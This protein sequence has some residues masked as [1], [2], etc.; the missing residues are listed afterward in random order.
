M[1][2]ARYIG[3]F[4]L[5]NEQCYIQGLGTLQLIRKPATYDG[6]EL[7]APYHE[8]TLVP[9]GNVDEA[10]ANY[11]ATNEQISITKASNALKEYSAE[12]RNTLQAGGEV[13]LPFLGRFVETDS[14]VGFVT[15]PYLLYKA[16]PIKA[17][18][19]ASLQ[20]NERPPL[21]IPHQPFIPTTPVGS[22]LATQQ[23]A[24]AMPPPAMP[25][26]QHYGGHEERERLNWARILFVLILM[27]V[28]AGG[29]Y[30]G[31]ER[32]MA[33]P[34]NKSGA[35]PVLTFPE[36]EPAMEEFP[37][38]STGAD[39]TMMSADT[40]ATAMDTTEVTE[41]P[42]VIPTSAKKDTAT[43]KPTVKMITTKIMLASADTKEEAY[44]LRKEFKGMGYNAYVIEESADYFPVLVD[45]KTT[46]GNSVKVE[47]SLTKRLNFQVFAY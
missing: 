40:S 29:A 38:D 44:K 26:A 36:E 24:P 11:I 4:L 6:H 3:L 17:Q 33:P 2:V 43:A 23:Q 22:P 39:S 5:K 21:P 37:A 20:H 27:M 25:H 41:Q 18:K 28:L 9:G 42:P 35:P 13:R 31:Y 46:H 45:I 19:G 34:K 16:P 30:Y 1:D 47:D 15:D 12:T 32:Y 10:L 7:H 8:I 14:K